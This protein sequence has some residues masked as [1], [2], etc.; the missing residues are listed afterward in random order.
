MGAVLQGVAAALAVVVI[1]LISAD[2]RADLK[3]EAIAARQIR[4]QLEHAT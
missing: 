2:R 1:A 4:A 3:R